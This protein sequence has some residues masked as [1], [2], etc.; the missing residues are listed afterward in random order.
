MTAALIQ[1]MSSLLAVSGCD[2]GDERDVLRTLKAAAEYRDCDIVVYSDAA[3]E[4]ARVIRAASNKL[5]V[6]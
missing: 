2:L 6:S 3:T 5:A 4:C 1:S